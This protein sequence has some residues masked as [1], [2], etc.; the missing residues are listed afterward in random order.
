M[1]LYLEAKIKNYLENN[2]TADKILW[3]ALVEAIQ[4][5][6]LLKAAFARAVVQRSSIQILN[7]LKERSYNLF[8]YL[9]LSLD[10]LGVIF[11]SLYPPDHASCTLGHAHSLC[12]HGT[13]SVHL[14]ARPL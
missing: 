13:R 10:V 4:P 11:P 8:E 7:I 12:A 14:G 9:F 6:F 5:N 1:L 2:R 3:M